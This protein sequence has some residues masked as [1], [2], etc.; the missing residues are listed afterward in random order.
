MHSV[1]W[2]PGP[3]IKKAAGE[4]RP[5]PI[6]PEQ[7][8]EGSPLASDRVVGHWKGG[9]QTGVWR[10][11]PGRFTDVKVDE[12]FVVLEGRASIR[13]GEAVHELRAGDVCVLRAGIETEWTVHETVVKVYVLDPDS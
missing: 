9:A 4:L 7:V 1:E 8:I 2:I 12:S 3:R 5:D 13:H 10:C 11:E 6:A